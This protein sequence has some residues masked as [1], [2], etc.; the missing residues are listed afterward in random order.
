MVKLGW[1]CLLTWMHASPRMRKMKLGSQTGVS[2]SWNEA[3]EDAL[4]CHTYS[5][6]L[7]AIVVNPS[8]SFLFTSVDLS[9]F[10][11]RLLLH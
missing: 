2:L 7:S 6:Y 4:R 1:F 10:P 5:A 11:N 8:F 3:I 9:G